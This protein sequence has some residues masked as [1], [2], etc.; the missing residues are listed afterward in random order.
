MHLDKN[1]HIRVYFKLI[2]GNNYLHY[3]RLTATSQFPHLHRQRYL[4]HI[5]HMAAIILVK[6]YNNSIHSIFH[7]L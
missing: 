5:I 2:I 4:L 7:T 1:V 3:N 6:F